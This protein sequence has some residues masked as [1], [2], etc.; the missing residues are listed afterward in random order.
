MSLFHL[1]F[2]FSLPREKVKKSEKTS[3]SAAH[4]HTW[5][6]SST[7]AGE[8]NQ[9]SYELERHFEDHCPGSYRCPYGIT[10]VTWT[11]VLQRDARYH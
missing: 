1:Q 6:K 3:K 11:H 10:Y 4:L 7:F 5:I 2:I 8:F 9:C